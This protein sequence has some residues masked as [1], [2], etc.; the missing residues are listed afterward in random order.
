MG[1]EKERSVKICLTQMFVCFFYS[2]LYPLRTE[3]QQ[4]KTEYNKHVQTY[5]ELKNKLYTK[6][7]KASVVIC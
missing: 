4:D 1:D 5:K 3:I 2:W 6:R 7:K